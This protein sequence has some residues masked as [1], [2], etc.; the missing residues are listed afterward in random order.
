MAVVFGNDV[1]LFKYDV[2]VVKVRTREVTRVTRGFV[3]RFPSLFR[4]ANSLPSF[5]R[6]ITAVAQV[7]GSAP[8]ISK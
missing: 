3:S 5:G 7:L 6:L 2:F 8:Q 4:R 1:T